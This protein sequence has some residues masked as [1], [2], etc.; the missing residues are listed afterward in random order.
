MPEGT[1]KKE[2]MPFYLGAFLA[3]AL[4][5]HAQARN[6]VLQAQ[7]LQALE[8]KVTALE[9]EKKTL[10]C[11]NKAYQST[12]KQAQEAKEKAEKQLAEAMGFQADFYTR[13]VALQVQL[14]GLQDLVEADAEVQKDLKDRC[15]EQAEEMERMEGEMT[16]QAKAMGLLQVDYDKLQVEVSRLRVE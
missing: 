6:A 3:V 16:T 5:W 2:G 14:T 11:Q 1:D 15:C 13:E 7:A 10:E 8:T 9:E 4:E 12:L